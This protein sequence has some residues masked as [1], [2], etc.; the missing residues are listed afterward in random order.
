MIV[1]EDR[2]IVMYILL[3][4]VTCG[5]YSYWFLYTMAQ[6]ANVVCA[7]DG[8]NT[9]GLVQFILLSLVTCGIYGWFWYYSLGNRLAENAPRYGL[10]FTENG[11][12]VLMWLIVGA[13]LCGIGP[14]IAMNIL[15]TNMNRLAHAYNV[16]ASN[17][18]NQHA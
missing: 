2:S 9:P 11:T 18:N 1:K 12:T 7:G 16:Y 6:D 17:A 8:K 10:T 13:L 14:F 3:S 5:I 4:L 15:I